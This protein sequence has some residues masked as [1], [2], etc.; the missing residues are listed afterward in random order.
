MQQ[1][2]Q[3]W[4]GVGVA[5]LAT[6]AIWTVGLGGGRLARAEPK[7]VPAIKVKLMPPPEY[8]KPTDQELRRKLQPMQYEVTQ[9]GETEPPF[10]NEFWDNHEA[11][12][13]VDVATGEPLFSS[14]DKFESGTGW[15]SFTRPVEPDRVVEQ[16]R[17]QPTA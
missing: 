11:G 9:K 7:P 10:D 17:P 4:G 12:L 8:S 13:Y 6:I 1:P 16:L 14:H 3:T 2:L 15:P 5:V